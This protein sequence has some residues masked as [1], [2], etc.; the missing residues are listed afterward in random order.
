MAWNM[1]L[2][3]YWKPTVPFSN[4][5]GEVHEV[6]VHVARL[7]VDQRIYFLDKYKRAGTPPSEMVTLSRR[8]DRPDELEL[9]EGTSPLHQAF[10]LPES[11]IRRRRI[12]EMSPDDYATLLEQESQE[13]AYSNEVLRET[14]CSYVTIPA[15][16]GVRVETASGQYEDVC[17]GPQI[18]EAFGQNAGILLR[19]YQE[20]H[21][22]NTLT[23]SAKNE[24]RLA[25]ASASS[26]PPSPREPGGPTPGSPVVP[27]GSAGCVAVEGAT[28]STEDQSGEPLG[29]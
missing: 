19:L 10:V 5:A 3:K 20:V 28:A 16:Q 14:I 27:V 7:T 8:M 17:T 1:K 18:M 21:H 2:P 9:V 25:S 24:L 6:T 15:G 11:E 23:G 26:S 29:T 13:E 4:E 12:S 22:Q